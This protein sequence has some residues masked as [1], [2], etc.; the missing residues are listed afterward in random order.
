MTHLANGHAHSRSWASAFGRASRL[1]AIGLDTDDR[2][3]FAVQLARGR[4]GWALRSVLSIS[5]PSLDPDESSEPS[6]AELLERSGFSGKRA[7]APAPADKLIRSL[8]D[9]PAR[10]AGLPLDQIAAQELARVHRTDVD[11][12]QT[13]WW[14]LPHPTRGSDATPALALGLA[15]ADAE[16]YTD[17]LE[18]QGVEIERLET[19][20]VAL[21]RAASGVLRQCGGVSAIA[22]LGWNQASILIYAKGTIVYERAV[23][24]LRALPVHVALSERLELDPE[25]VMHAMEHIGLVG[26]G[27]RDSLPHEAVAILREHVDAIASELHASFS[28]VAHRYNDEDLGRVLLAGPHASIPGLASTIAERLGAECDLLTPAM[29]VEVP[30]SLQSFA[31]ASRL[32]TAIGLAMPA[33]QNQRLAEDSA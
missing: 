13:A 22:Y 14:E 19:R 3:V 21:A 23:D 29:L 8:L 16:A 28:Y 6:L 33:S 30:E 4:S 15:H 20:G 11:A 24:E 10:Q 32:C 12:L 25:L 18:A 2:G 31:E 1:T 7:I 27:R 9:L 26:D 17:R 5:T